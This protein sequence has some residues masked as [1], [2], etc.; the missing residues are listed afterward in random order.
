[1]DMIFFL[2][3]AFFDLGMMDWACNPLI[4]IIQ[5]LTSRAFAASLLCL[6]HRIAP[7]TWMIRFIMNLRL[8][9]YPYFLLR[10]TLL[11]ANLISIVNVHSSMQ[12]AP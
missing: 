12:S 7:K 11:R 3:W 4:P 8:I 5:I 10:S 6:M 1:M 9:C 2:N